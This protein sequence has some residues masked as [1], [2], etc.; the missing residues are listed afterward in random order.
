[1]LNRP[2]F[3][4]SFRVEKVEPET[5]F[6]LSERA[7]IASIDPLYFRLAALIDGDRTAENIVGEMLP[8]LVPNQ[9][10]FQEM[11]QAGTRAY[12][13]LAKMERE[14]YLVE[15]NNHLPPE[16]AMFCDTLNIDL[17]EA[18]RRLQTTKVVVKTL[19]SIPPDRLTVILES[20]GIQVSTEGEL[21][22]VLCD[23]YLQEDLNLIN[24]QALQSDRPWMLVKPVGTVIWLGPIFHPG[25]T[26]CWQCLAQRLKDNRPIE[27]F[28]QRQ[29]QISTPITPPLNCL[30]SNLQTALGMA[31]SEI[32]KWIVQGK[33][34]RLEGKIV[35]YDSLSLTI[36]DHVLVKRPQ[37][38]C[39][40]D[41]NI[42]REPQPLVLES[43]KKTFT[44]EGGHRCKPPQ[45]TLRQYQHHISAI[46]GVVRELQKVSANFNGLTHSYVARHHFAATN[47]D[48][49]SLQQNLS[50]R[51]AGKGQTDW[52]AKASSF[53]EAIERYS[54]SFQGNEKR[55]QASY[56]QL[57]DRAIH[58]NECTNFS[59]EQYKNRQV[60]N[61]NCSS[62][63]QKVPEPFDE[64]REIEWTPVWSLTAGEFKYLPTA[65]C[66]HGYPN[67][68]GDCWADT[69]GCATGN[70]LEEAILQGFLE[71]VERDCVALWW[72]NR[73][74]RPEVDLDS[75]E[76]PYFQA[77]KDYYRSID[78]DLWVLDLTSD[79]NIPTFAAITRRIDREVEDIVLGFGCHFD[80]KIAIGRALTEVNQIMPAVASTN[81]DGTSHY[82]SYD[83]IAIEWWK[84]ATQ[85]NQTYLVPDRNLSPKVA[86][87]YPQHGSDDLLA[88]VL[89]CQKIA[90]NNDLEMLVLDLTRP[91]IGLN[92]VKVIVPGMRH[93]WKRLGKGRL[94]DIPVKIGWLS[95]SLTEDRLNP[96][97]MWM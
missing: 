88:D 24:K 53:C 41:T 15:S 39:C 48:L 18:N 36:K 68:W 92:V 46:T 73:L 28:I 37:C 70:S 8:D 51:S 27:S 54:A 75:F 6:L 69:N 93:W 11:I 32:L 34:Q 85:E 56:S 35:T 57:G 4:I 90:E 45:E 79:F 83:P 77:L 19:G 38:P 26:G 91:D 96:F 62:F 14:G 89:T 44:A 3:R 22:V 25:K 9:A 66:Y 12:Y 81:P 63:F 47:D 2:R 1:M 29:N 94:Y 52:Q 40:G 49:I 21:E 78:R 64:Q 30:A 50:G 71:L 20:L 80:A 43:C 65:Y 17:T 84:T 5:V 33:N 74:K 10:S 13:T 16:L 95:Q 31:A 60:W 72:Y 7:S 97:P 59:Q 58:P 76:Q 23:D 42:D 87:D 82:L 61:S 67:P 55:H 86:A